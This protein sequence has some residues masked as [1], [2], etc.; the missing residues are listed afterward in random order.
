M[1]EAPYCSQHQRYLRNGGCI[2]CQALELV[3]LYAK[4]IVETWPKMSM[5]TLGQMT[6]RIDTLRQAL[7]AVKKIG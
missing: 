6:Q 4:D 7:E 1:S 5:R 3:V 2:D